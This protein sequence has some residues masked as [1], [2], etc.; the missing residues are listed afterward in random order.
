MCDYYI[1]ETILFFENLA[2]LN[3]SRFL[4]LKKEFFNFFKARIKVS[5][6]GQYKKLYLIIYTYGQ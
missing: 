6:V 5:W 3:Y 2:S 4:G 1:N